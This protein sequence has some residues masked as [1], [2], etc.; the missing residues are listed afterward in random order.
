MKK[1]TIYT[2]SYSRQIN[3]GFP[4]SSA[5]SIFQILNTMTN[6]LHQALLTLAMLLAL[7]GA[8]LCAQ[9]KIFWSE[10]SPEITKIR[11]ANLDGTNA[12]DIIVSNFKYPAS[13][14]VD[15]LAGKLYWTEST[16]AIRRSNL[17]GS[18][19]E[20]LL[21]VT[22]PEALTLDLV[23]G[24]MYFMDE[25]AT[26]ISRANL[27]GTNQEVLY[28]DN[29]GGWLSGM[30]LDIAAGK[31][32]VCEQIEGSLFRINT[33]GANMEVL[34]PVGT[35]YPFDVRLDVAAGKMY[36]VNTGLG[37]IYRSSLD[38]S[39][40][41][42]IF[43]PANGGAIYIELDLDNGKIY[44]A[45][46]SN[47]KLFRCN[48]DGSNIEEV[49]SSGL[50]YSSRLA[51]DPLAD[52]MYW[53]NR[54]DHFIKRVNADGSGVETIHDTP[55]ANPAGFS[56]DLAGSKMY[57]ADEDRILRANFDGS[58]M[59]TI[60]SNPY[61]F[62]SATALDVDNSKIYWAA[63]NR[64]I[65]RSNLDGSNVEQLI[66]L[67]TLN[68]IQSIFLDLGN[69]KMYWGNINLTNQG[70]YRANLDGSGVETVHTG[71][72]TANVAV[73]NDK[74]YWTAVGT[75]RGIRRS[76]LDGSNVEDLVTTQLVTPFRLVV[77]PVNGKLLW[78]DINLDM[79]ERS[80]LDGS[81]RETLLTG[82]GPRYF[83]IHEN[84]DQT[85]TV[86][87]DPP[88]TT[89]PVAIC[90]DFLMISL[91]SNYS[92]TIS[93][94]DLDEGSYDLCDGSLTFS[95]NK[96]V[97][98]CN[99]MQQGTVEVELTVTNSA[100]LSNSCS[101]TVYV[102]PPD[103]PGTSDYRIRFPADAILDC[104]Q[105]LNSNDDILTDGCG[106][107]GISVQD[108][109]ITPSAGECI[110][111]ERTYSI[112]N[113]AEYSGGP[114]VVIRRDE[115][116]NGTAGDKDIWVIK[117]AN[118]Q[119]FLDSD[120]DETNSIPAANEKGTSCDGLTNPAGYWINNAM[121]SGATPPRNLNSNG[122]WQY[123]R[124]IRVQSSSG[125]SIIPNA[126]YGPFCVTDF[127]NCRGNATATF[128]LQDLCTPNNYQIVIHFDENNDATPDQLLDNN[129]Y[130]SG[131]LPFF[132]IN[133]LFPEGQHAFII[134]A[135]DGCNGIS[136]LTIPFAIG[137]NC[138]PTSIECPP[139]QTIEPASG[140]CEIQVPDL[141]GQL[142]TLCG[143][144]EQI[145]QTPA[146]GTM[147]GLGTHTIGISVVNGGGYVSSCVTNI[148]VDGLP[149]GFNDPGN[150][151]VGSSSGS[152]S[153]NPDNGVFAVNS[154]NGG[155]STT[156]DNV[157]FIPQQ[158]CGDGEITAEIT[159]I[160]SNG[161]AGVM[162]R[163]TLDPGAKKFAIYTNFGAN[164]KRE[165]RVNTNGAANIGQ[166][167]RPN[168]R[169]LRIRRIGNSLTAFASTNGISWSMLI[170]A[171]FGMTD[172]IQVGLATYSLSPSIP[173]YATFDNVQVI[174]YA[175]LIDPSGGNQSLSAPEVGLFPNPATGEVTLQ[176][177]AAL[178][179]SADLDIYDASGR[180]V[181]RRRW[182]I[183]DQS[184]ESLD[185]STL[186]NGVYMVRIE[187][188]GA[189]PAIIRM[190][191]A[192]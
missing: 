81:N 158:L 42:L 133:G 98:D 19:S 85:F 2:L 141:T 45:D 153:Y 83:A 52:K 191:M 118:G 179:Q 165:I 110:K 68:T 35:Y 64:F 124:I 134:S 185:L 114:P 38:G 157:F 175:P 11:K 92:A 89:P 95:A 1:Y 122:Y 170:S 22:G 151:G 186:E 72:R 174:D 152:V 96:T 93:P 24:K 161:F 41:E 66:S 136:T 104:A 71:Y 117:K 3:S 100:S 86:T 32:Y 26:Q 102:A 108:V 145:D 65:R 16:G 73:A 44:W 54:E 120:G 176:W 188:E 5:I 173:V 43:N 187:Q 159:S 97:F 130:L 181:Y 7:P 90:D 14:A 144:Y 17:D 140:D 15:A 119:V 101:V 190:I 13:V 4:I 148:T 137:A 78:S 142:I 61:D 171:S 111:V 55:I 30:S 31:I 113:W 121:G 156:S 155:S 69:G 67:G 49:L 166:I 51:Y 75:N 147:L 57:W 20:L 46:G 33:D 27:D 9:S 183:V 34:I 63:G 135:Y 127:A 128:Y 109:F 21:V 160:S 112:I 189:L 184:T 123:T 36:W 162:M 138:G 154:T 131:S 99:D 40:I 12:E 29:Y 87:V 70:L 47:E 164:V 6:P 94:T 18:N 76:D 163:E 105:A 77:D 23:N 125:P 192:N 79:L 177:G 106:L 48:L 59:E 58:D 132:T 82:V 80:N 53:S 169:W 172:C 88:C 146:P 74:L 91:N 60:V 139:A 28:V 107:F 103:N 180:L 56:V 115:D 129:Q 37:E 182:D 39:D 25:G 168:S 143:S 178:G 149:C 10:S 116:C 126:T 50:S 8:Y 150:Q 62:I 84:I 167:Y